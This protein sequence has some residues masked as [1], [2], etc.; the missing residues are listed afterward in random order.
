ML[1]RPRR[2]AVAALTFHSPVWQRSKK[3]PERFKAWAERPSC[4]CKCVALRRTG[5]RGRVLDLYTSD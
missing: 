5:G 1:P 2:S 4:T 3:T